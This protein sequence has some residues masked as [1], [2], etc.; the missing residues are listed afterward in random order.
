MS[1][2]EVLQLIGYSTGAA[3]H[4]WM[5]GL[6]LKRR[7]SLGKMERVLLLLAFSIG[8]WHAAN[9][10]ITLHASLGLDP[11]RW[12]VP[13][14]LTDSIAV[15]SI[16]LSYSFL[17]H[18]HLHLWAGAHERPLKLNER[19]RVYLT[20]IPALFLFVAVPRLW[21]GPYQPMMEKLND[22]V[23][24]FALWAGYGLIFVAVTDLLISRV[25]RERSER[26]SMR[27]LAASFIG[28]AVLLVAAYA[29]G[30]GQGTTLG[31]Y[32]KT[33]ANLGSL[34]PSALIA[35]YIYRYR[36]LELII[37]ESLIVATLATVVLAVYLFGIRSFAAWLAGNY[38]LRAGTIEAL[39]ILGLVLAAAPIRQWLEN[40]FHKLFE[41]EAALYRDVV[42]RI[43]QRAGQHQT[44]AELL[45]FVEERAAQALELRRVRIVAVESEPVVTAKQS[46]ALEVEEEALT[47]TDE[48]V[49]ADDVMA[50]LRTHKWS[51]V[52][53]ERCLRERGFEMAFALRREDRTSGFMLV[54]AAPDALTRDVRAVL[55]VL[56]GQVAIAIEDFRLVEENVRLERRLAQGERLAALGRMAAT[57]AHEVKNPLSAIKSIAQVM[58]EDK[59]LAAEYARDLSLI[60]GETDR[61]SR[62]VTQLLSF[63]RSA[64]PDA[65]PLSAEELVRA[66]TELFK[67]EARTRGITL[68]CRTATTIELAGAEAS[69]V[70]DALSN[71]LTNALQAT[72]RGGFVSVDARTQGDELL[73][74]IVDGG[75]GIQRELRERIWEPF[76]T[77]KQRGTGLG[78]AIVRKRMEEVGGRATLSAQREHEGARFTLRVPL[79]A[80][81]ERERKPHLVA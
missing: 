80:S 21:V 7:S 46:D 68:E 33:F 58:R 24:P 20:Y 42:G 53:S 29:F 34:L 17:L 61:L 18:V 26:N 16:T 27:A 5:S 41:R 13:L 78:L 1:L 9:L 72:P 38:G 23:L 22:M 73:I 8:A 6:L 10:L 77:T 32:L 63:A 67:M 54:D 15:T 36:Y 25:A 50:L 76:F 57:V 81:V 52:E 51:P 4:L 28:I 65:A 39:L 30:V 45:R 35:Y 56:A 64:P 48:D 55:E 19:V 71:L 79:R 62:S 60:V 3:L 43:G 14:R 2:L 37:K 31:H 59:H 40:R 12:I 47:K 11:N 70:R 69:A 66:V 44:L 74:E 49:W 75:A